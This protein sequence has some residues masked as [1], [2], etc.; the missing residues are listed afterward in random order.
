MKVLVTG[1]GGFVGG[2]VARLLRRQG[3]RVRSFSR[4]AHP[5]LAAEG[6]EAFRGDVSDAFA[7]QEACQGMDA[8]V[9]TAARVGLWG[10]YA[11]FYRVNVKGTANVIKA[12]QELGVP[13]LVFTSSPSVVFDG[14]DVDGWDESAPYSRRFDSHYSRTKALAE[15]MVLASNTASLATVALRPHLVWGPGE[16]HILSRIVDRARAGKLRRVGNSNKR[17]D[18]SYVDDTAL[19]HWLALQRL[20]ASCAI[21][22]KAYFLSQGE[23]RPLWDIVNGML[24]A[25]DLPPVER[26]VAPLAAW[27]AA[28]G[29][30]AF[31]L[32]AR[33]KEEPILTRFLISQL[34]TAH[35]FDISAARRDLGFQPRVSIDA[36]LERLRVWFAEKRT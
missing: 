13:K 36:G 2:A 34:T 8:V 21:A 12:C 22:G 6:I 30:E 9:H 23:P 25:A 5:E 28:Y 18:T 32:A 3:L 19:A 10:D 17:V 16:N 20:D 1:G 15:E 33:R 35:W 29:L 27:A 24:R 4:A 31:Y 7:V 26:S 11:N 14:R